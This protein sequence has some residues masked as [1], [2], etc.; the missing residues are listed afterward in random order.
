MKKDLNKGKKKT[1]YHKRLSNAFCTKTRRQKKKPESNLKFLNTLDLL[2][3]ATMA[4]LQ[5][6]E[7][8]VSGSSSG[9]VSY[10]DAA[11]EDHTGGQIYLSTCH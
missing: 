5:P 2:H 8:E 7:E 3:N 11:E 6:E 1:S 9:G 4:S 10:S